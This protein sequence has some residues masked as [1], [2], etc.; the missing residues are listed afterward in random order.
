MN[1]KETIKILGVDDDPAIREI[2]RD[3]LSASGYAVTTAP[4]GAQAL[5]LL[6]VEEYDLVLADISMPGMDGLTLYN[7]AVKE[8]ETLRDRFLFITGD[9]SE[10]LLLVFSR[11]N[12]K[13]LWKPFKMIDLLNCVDAM[14]AKPRNKNGTGV[15]R[16]RQEE[17]MAIQKDCRIT[18]VA[19]NK[20]TAARTVDI[21][22]SGMRVLYGGAPLQ[23]DQLVTVNMELAPTALRRAAK[24]VWSRQ[25]DARINAAG[26]RFCDAVFVERFFM[27]GVESDGRP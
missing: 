20:F 23:R 11:M 22:K 25:V 16:M 15:K 9:I 17:R 5:A 1:E 6:R 3:V 18:G 7:C 14:T 2:C 13:Y 26:L 19:D 24:I 4:D 21:S 27:R 12:L 10:E 8:S